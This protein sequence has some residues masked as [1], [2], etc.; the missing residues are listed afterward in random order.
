MPRGQLLTL[1]N[2]RRRRDRVKVAAALLSA[3]A[4]QE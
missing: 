2:N 3:G 4:A 1:L